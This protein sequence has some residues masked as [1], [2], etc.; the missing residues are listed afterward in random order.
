MSSIQLTHYTAIVG[1]H[2]TDDLL[3]ALDGRDDLDVTLGDGS[4]TAR[5][6]AIH[7]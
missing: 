6:A 4:Q 1:V 5:R 7:R 3:S 2:N